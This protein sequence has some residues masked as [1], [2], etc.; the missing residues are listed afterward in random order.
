MSQKTFKTQSE[1]I[2]NTV[3]KNKKKQKVEYEA[4]SQQA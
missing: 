1:Q 2:N 4:E 3:Y